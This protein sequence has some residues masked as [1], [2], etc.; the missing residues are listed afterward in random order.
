[1]EDFQK[2]AQGVYLPGTGSYIRMRGSFKG[3]YNKMKRLPDA[4]LNPDANLKVR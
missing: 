4:R 3:F 1:M 2:I